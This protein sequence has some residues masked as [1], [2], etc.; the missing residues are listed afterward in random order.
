MLRFSRRGLDPSK[1]NLGQFA[2]LLLLDWGQLHSP[3]PQPP[4]PCPLSA[5]RCLSPARGHVRGFDFEGGQGPDATLN[6]G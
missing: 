5:V 1:G 3:A 6:Q 4:A 2:E